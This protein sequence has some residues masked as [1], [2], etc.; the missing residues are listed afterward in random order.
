M[1]FI[2][3]TIPLLIAL[4]IGFALMAL[5]GKDAAAAYE[6]LLTA[7]VTRA[8]RAGRWI[9]ASSVF[10]LAGL[11]ML[12][13]YKIRALNFSLP[14]QAAAGAF[15]AFLVFTIAPL[16]DPAAV[17]AACCAAAAAGALIAMIPGA[18]KAW[19]G[20]NEIVTG[21]MLTPIV[22]GLL[23]LLGE[24]IFAAVQA[25]GAARAAVRNEPFGFLP[26]QAPGSPELGVL[27]TGVLLTPLACLAAWLLLRRMPIGFAIRTVGA[28]ERFARY[29]GVSVPRTI[30]AAFAAGGAFAG[31]AGA[32]MALGHP[33][34]LYLNVDG[35]TF[36]GLTVALIAGASPAALP[37]AGLLYGYLVVGAE[38]MEIRTSSGQELIRVIQGLVVLFAVVRLRETRDFAEKMKRR[39]RIKFTRDKESD[40]RRA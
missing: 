20:A 39:L 15:A 36:D 32:H 1:S 10:I 27:H 6:V 21:L 30:L 14:A 9:E 25:S 13:P 7:P 4:A 11:A 17:V 22:Q 28:N 37:V 24:P 8:A 31:L 18:L 19:L 38:Y 26:L 23:S 29:A 34:G 5:S 2:R 40:D 35:L 33:G 16:P 12:A 3:R